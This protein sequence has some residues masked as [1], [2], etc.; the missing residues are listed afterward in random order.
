MLGRP[1]NRRI[2]DDVRGRDVKTA[3]EE[4][5]YK[6]VRCDRKIAEE[7]YETHRGLCEDCHEIEVDELDLEDS[8]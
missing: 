8:R 6:C 5:V 1:I 4:K 3:K 7:E 2:R